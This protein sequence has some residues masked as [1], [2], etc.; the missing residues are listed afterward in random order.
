M[1]TFTL[2]Y[3]QLTQIEEFRKKHKHENQNSTIG[4]KLSFIFTPTSIGV[5]TDIK[6]N[7]CNEIK[8]ITNYNNW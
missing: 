3:E 4:G 6:C 7:A 1:K 5:I 8:D 2:N